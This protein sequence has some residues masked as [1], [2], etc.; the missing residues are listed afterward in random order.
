MKDNEDWE[1]CA[2]KTVE[3]S[4]ES[5]TVKYEYDLEPSGDLEGEMDLG[6]MS[7]SMTQDLTKEFDSFSQTDDICYYFYTE[8]DPEYAPEGL[9][10][11]LRLS[12]Y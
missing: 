12:V 9:E 1:T 2:A 8:Y 7:V 4:A 5:G 3:G 11:L 6:D 10:G